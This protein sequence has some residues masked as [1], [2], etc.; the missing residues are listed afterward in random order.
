VVTGSKGVELCNLERG[1]LVAA[2]SDR[3][4]RGLPPLAAVRVRAA[5]G[6][7]KVSKM[8]TPRASLSG[9]MERETDRDLPPRAGGSATTSIPSLGNDLAA[10]ALVGCSNLD[11]EDSVRDEGGR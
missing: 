5:A 8:W 3:N 10:D 11:F 1:A 4:V 7:T 9:E 2:G 6:L